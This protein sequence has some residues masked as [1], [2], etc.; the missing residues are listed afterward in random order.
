M[1]KI[2]MGLMAFAAVTGIGSAF[3]FNAPKKQIGTTY[4]ASLSGSNQVWSLTPPSG[5][6]CQSGNTVACTITSTSPQADVLATQNDFPDNYTVQ[7]ASDN[8]IYR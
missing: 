3:A 5:K 7:H 8:K 4:Y 2:R 6:S 1:K